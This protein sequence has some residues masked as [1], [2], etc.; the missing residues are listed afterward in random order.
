MRAINCIFYR[1]FNQSTNNVFH[2]FYSSLSSSTKCSN[3]CVCSLQCYHSLSIQPLRVAV[4][5]LL[6]A[7][8]NLSVTAVNFIVT[9]VHLLPKVAG[10]RKYNSAFRIFINTQIIRYD[11]TVL[12]LFLLKENVQ[13]DL[14]YVILK[15]LNC[16]QY[17]VMIN[18]YT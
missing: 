13:R 16:K 3:H 18:C 1:I 17:V 10:K 14:F 9:E 4:H 5:A 11:A 12:F 6:I 15:E 8:W 2:V 7:T